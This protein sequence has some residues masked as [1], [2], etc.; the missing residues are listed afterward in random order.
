MKILLVAIVLAVFSILGCAEKTT[1]PPEVE[2]IGASGTGIFRTVPGDAVPAIQRGLEHLGNQNF[3]AALAEFLTAKQIAGEPG[4][5]AIEGYIG[6]TYRRLGQPDL[7]IQHYTAAIS[8]DDDIPLYINR[9]AAYLDAGIP[10]EA[11]EDAEVVLAREPLTKESGSHSHAEA[12]FLMAYSLEFLGQMPEALDAW[13][14]ALRIANEYGGYSD[15]AMA[16]LNAERDRIAASL[17]AE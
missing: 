17:A 10:A 1:V 14:N 16:N 4:S 2:T 11:I 13:D 6:L 9:A 7:A 8:L 12:Y 15:A 5:S 3:D